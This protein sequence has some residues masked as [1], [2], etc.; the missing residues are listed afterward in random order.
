LTKLRPFKADPEL[1]AIRRRH[2]ELARIHQLPSVQPPDPKFDH[3]PWCS[4]SR[5]LPIGA[6]GNCC[7]CGRAFER[8]FNDKYH[9][10]P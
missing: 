5:R 1:Y 8:I 9:N 10:L 4:G 7:I 2:V 3:L 6:K